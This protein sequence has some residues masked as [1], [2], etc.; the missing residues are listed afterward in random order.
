MLYALSELLSQWYEIASPLRLVRYITFR[1]IIAMLTSF[2]ITLFLGRFVINWLYRRKV[3]DV[4]RDYSVMSVASKKGTPTMGGV[5]MILSILCTV[6]L[7]GNFHS[8]FV[9]YLL[10]ATVWFAVVGGMDDY[11]KI[12]YQDSDKGL[13]RR[14]KYLSQIG[15]GLIF[16]FFFLFSGT[17]P[18][19]HLNQQSECRMPQKVCTQKCLKDR[20]CVQNR[21]GYRQAVCEEGLCVPSR[22]CLGEEPLKCQGNTS[23]QKRCGEKAYCWK[24]WQQ[25]IAGIQ[26]LF[27]PSQLYIPFYKYPILDLSWLYLLV[28]MFFVVFAANA[29]NFADGLDGLATGPTLCSYLVFGIY[30]YVLGNALISRYLLFPSLPGAGEVAVFCGAVAGALV[31]F[32]WFNTYPAEIFMGDTGS[33]T[34]GG[35]LGTVMVLLK[36]ETL[37]FLLGGIFVAE[38]ASVAIQDWLGIQILGRRLFYRAPIHHTFQH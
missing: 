25:N 16:G 5:L 19:P 6:L 8:A 20:D 18:L 36:Q 34:L 10:F 23:C 38:I 17:T 1:T 33:I 11:L 32:L 26:V 22:T 2:L 24:P 30:A 13:S 37:F 15:Y 3:R 7:W 35:L 9:Y 29:V 14:A 28:I 27:R 12:K 31:G 4:V 21:C